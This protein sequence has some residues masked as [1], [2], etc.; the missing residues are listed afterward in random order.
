MTQTAVKTQKQV[1]VIA[2]IELKQH[3]GIIV[4]KVRSSNGVD[5]YETVIAYGKASSCTCPATKP[6]YHMT[7]LEAK[8]QERIAL[9][10]RIDQDIEQHLEDEQYP[11]RLTRAQ[12]VAEFGIYS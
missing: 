6:C 7:Q 2:R 8:E 9:E 12:F 10:H 11:K 4:Y 5:V 3:P 1:Q